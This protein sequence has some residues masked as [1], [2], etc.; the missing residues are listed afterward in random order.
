MLHTIACSPLCTQH[1]HHMQ[2]F[3]H[4]AHHM[5]RT[6][7]ESYHYTDFWQIETHKIETSA[8]VLPCL[9]R[10]I[11][12]LC[13]SLYST[14]FYLTPKCQNTSLHEVNSYTSLGDQGIQGTHQTIPARPCP[15][16]T[17]RCP[18]LFYTP[19]CTYQHLLL[20]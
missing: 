8:Y 19:I 1:A 14:A 20:I 2:S 12:I 11:G 5:S 6:P 16:R 17:W 3:V 9:S 7:H 10:D 4:A 18:S 15:L 13:T